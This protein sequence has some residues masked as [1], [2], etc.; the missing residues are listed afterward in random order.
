MR[1]IGQRVYGR[2]DTLDPL[3]GYEGKAIPAAYHGVRS[4]MKD[5]LPTDDQVFPADLQ[6]N[7][8]RTASA[9]SSIRRWRRT[10][11]GP[12]VDAALL[13]AG[14]GLDWDTAEFERAAE[15]V[16]NL[17]RAITSSATG[18][19]R[20][21]WTSACSPLSSTT[22]T[23]ST[24]SWATRM[25]LDREQ[26]VPVMDEYYR[27]R[28]WDVETGWPTQERLE[29]LGLGDVY[30]EMV[31]GAESAS[32]RLPELAPVAPVVDVHTKD[33]ERVEEQEKSSLL[34]R[35]PPPHAIGMY[36]LLVSE[37][38]VSPWQQRAARSPMG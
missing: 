35:W 29:R 21:R 34:G 24:P 23:G 31:A 28:G 22:R 19:A 3:S 16:L 8:P 13:R 27:L 36:E 5:C 6:P 9:A 14:T 38:V 4:I 10:I 33:A 25:A 12:D 30:D 17:E 20:G 7:T 18:A 2:A 1:G 37:R 11:D 32:A 15:R 26:F